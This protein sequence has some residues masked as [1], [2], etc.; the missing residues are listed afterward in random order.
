MQEFVDAAVTF[1]TQ[2]E[3]LALLSAQNK[4]LV[5][6]AQLHVDLRT[7]NQQ[8][9]DIVATARAMSERNILATPLCY[10]L[11]SLPF[12]DVLES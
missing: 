10:N 2:L 6:E 7:S 8:G 3:E 4:K 9:K 1:Q 11:L 12:N 5:Q